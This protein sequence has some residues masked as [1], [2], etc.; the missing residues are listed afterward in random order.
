MSSTATVNVTDE[1][2]AVS[3]NSTEELLS[4]YLHRNVTARISRRILHGILISNEEQAKRAQGLRSKQ[5][6]SLG[7][8]HHVVLGQD[9][10]DVVLP[11][12]GQAVFRIIG[13]DHNIKPPSAVKV[14]CHR[15][16]YQRVI[17]K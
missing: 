7:I 13:G 14:R 4:R 17:P 15:V 11:H 3:R 10:M 2:F 8:V 6:L 16:S 1:R 12:S 5:V 9:Y